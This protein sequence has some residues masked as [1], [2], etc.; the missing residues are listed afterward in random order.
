MHIGIIGAGASGLFAA[1]LASQNGARV[2][3]FERND[4]PGKKLL[5]TGSGRCNLSHMEADLPSHY[6]GSFL[7]EELF[8]RFSSE[9]IRKTFEAW[10]LYLVSDSSGRFYPRSYQSSSVLDVLRFTCMKNHVQFRFNTKV[11]GL[12]PNGS[13]CNLSDSEGHHYDLD[14]ILLCTGGACAPQTGSDGNAFSLLDRLD[15]SYHPLQPALVPLKTD[16]SLLRGMEG[17]RFHGKVSFLRDGYVLDSRLGEI[18]ISKDGFLSGI[19]VM[20]L[21]HLA[22]GTAHEEISIH[23]ADSLSEQEIRT[24]IRNFPD[25]DNPLG[26][27][28]NKRVGFLLTKRASSE[29][30]LVHLVTDFRLPVYGRGSFSQAQVTQGGVC[31]SELDPSSLSLK[32]FPNLY[33]CGEAVDIHG[34]CGGFNLSWAWASAYQAVSACLERGA[35]V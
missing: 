7:P 20:D 34:D 18:Q 1:A 2:T 11:T 28:L 4:R 29:N 30:E 6:H 16:R 19:C 22:A 13:R 35:A 23:L 24:S 32:R 15:V 5:L 3:V 31:G 12:K 9:K 8:S 10:G 26:G 17:L 21:S 27:I 14:A 33:C 25:P